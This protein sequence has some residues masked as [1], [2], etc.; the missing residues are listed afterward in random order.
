MHLRFSQS[1]TQGDAVPQSAPTVGAVPNFS[2]LTYTAGTA[3]DLCWYCRNHWCSYGNS[4]WCRYK[5]TGQFV[6]EITVID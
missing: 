2:S 5:C 1:Y 4:R 6:S 3:G